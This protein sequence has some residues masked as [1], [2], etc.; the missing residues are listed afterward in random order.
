MPH[1][2]SIN[3]AKR[4]VRVKSKKALPQSIGRHGQKKKRT[5]PKRTPAEI[6]EAHHRQEQ[7]LELRMAGTTYPKIAEALGY[8][9]ASSAKAAVDAVI[10]R[11]DREASKE[12]VALDLARLDEYQMRCTHQLR[13]NGDLHQID[14]LMRIMEM[15]YRLLGITDEVVRSMQENHG[16]SVTNKN[17]VM[18]IHTAPETE[19]EFVRKMM[20]AVGVN[21]D[22][23]VAKNLLSEHAIPKT[24]PML[25]GSANVSGVRVEVEDTNSLDEDDIVEAE[26]VEEL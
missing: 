21:P 25:E 10:G 19:E 7:A 18:N 24:L 23:Q 14:R 11:T 2:N 13:A 12:I 3:K 20:R 16:I 8:A 1:E 6:A 15:R 9:N 26:V 4:S 22:S 5:G 17:M